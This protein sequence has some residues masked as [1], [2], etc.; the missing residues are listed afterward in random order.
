MELI[1]LD[2]LALLARGLAHLF[3]SLFYINNTRIYGQWNHLHLLLKTNLFFLKASD[4]EQMSL[5]CQ[6]TVISLMQDM[7]D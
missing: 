6:E 5:K 4:E 7:S 1:Q 2:T 3:P